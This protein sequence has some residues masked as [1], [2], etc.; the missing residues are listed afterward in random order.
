VTPRRR[1]TRKVA[2]DRTAGA[3]GGGVAGGG[4]AVADSVAA[5]TAARGDHSLGLSDDL[6]LGEA[7]VA[8]R[9]AL[10]RYDA[11]HGTP[12]ESADEDD[13]ALR[14]LGAAS[15]PRGSRA[16]PDGGI[17]RPRRG[18]RPEVAAE[19]AAAEAAAAEAA[20]VDEAWRRAYDGSDRSDFLDEAEEEV[21]R[22]D[23]G[24]P[25]I[26]AGEC[27]DVRGCR[28]DDTRIDVPWCY[29]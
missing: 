29:V 10:A 4:A 3:A 13:V 8:Y 25:G 15:A 18:A 11:A 27:V 6:S 21:V 2:A 19:V 17:A 16:P 12:A 1:G 22:D 9:A 7:L 28:W 20:A 26:S 14:A 24:Y 5:G 23:C